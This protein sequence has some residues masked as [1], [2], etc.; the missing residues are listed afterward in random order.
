MTPPIKPIA[1]GTPRMSP[2]DLQEQVRLATQDMRTAPQPTQ[3]NPTDPP[4]PPPRVNTVPGF[5]QKMLRGFG[6]YASPTVLGGRVVD[7]ARS[8]G[9]GVVDAGNALATNAF[10]LG[11]S[12]DRTTGLGEALTPGFNAAFD[13]PGEGVH[14][15]AQDTG[16]VS[17]HTLDHFMG[18]RSDDPMAS[19]AESAAQFLTTYA[20]VPEKLGSPIIRAGIAQSLGFDP[21]EAGLAALAAQSPVPIARQLGQILKVDGDDSFL[22]AHLKTATEGIISIAL[23]DG[24]IASARFLGAKALL[25][26]G[27]LTPKGVALQTARQAEAAT[28]MTQVAD[29]SY[30][31]PGEA[32][33]VTP[34]PNG[35]WTLKA[36]PPGDKPVEVPLVDT[37]TP[38]VAPA[39]GA[40]PATP[41][42]DAPPVFRDYGE[43]SAQATTMNDRLTAQTEAAAPLDHPIT[44]R[45]ADAV[46]AEAKR[47]LGLTKPE[48]LA[49]LSAEVFNPSYANDLPHSQAV[50]DAV[51]KILK[52]EFDAAQRR[53]GGVPVEQSIAMLRSQ[54][55]AIPERELPAMMLGKLK[56]LQDQ[57]L[58]LLGGD[59][60]MR[61]MGAKV[62]DMSAILDARPHDLVAQD[63]A[64][65]AI[66]HLFDVMYWLAGANSETGRALAILKE[67][68]SARMAAAKI[69]PRLEAGPAPVK[70]A[71]P[72]LDP[73]TVNLD[74]TAK[75]PV[76]AGAIEKTADGPTLTGLAPEEAALKSQRKPSQIKTSAEDVAPAPYTAGMRPREVAAVARMVRSAG[77]LPRNIYAVAQAASIVTKGGRVDRA[78][79]FFAN[80]MLSGPKTHMSVLLSGVTTSL[81]EP[82]VK[83]GTGAVMANRAQML[84]GVDR[85]YGLF[86]YA[87][88]N[89]KSY[90]EALD[91]GRSIINPQPMHHEISG[92]TGD[93][94]RLP[95]RNLMALDE[96]T[97][98]SNYRAFVRARILRVNRASYF[99]LEGPALAMHVDDGL[100][101]AF[102]KNTGI[103]LF[104]EALKY[105]EVP[106]FSGAL[107]D[108]T[109][110]GRAH[111]YI[112]GG[113]ETRLVAMFVKASVNLFRYTWQMTP[114]L[115]VLNKQALETMKAGGEAAAELHARSL[116]GLSLFAFGA[117]QAG[118]DNLTGSGPSD[119]DM[120]AEWRKTH[121]PYSIRVGG[122]WMSYRRADPFATPLG[123]MADMN[124]ILHD[125]ENKSAD[126][127]HIGYAFLAA[128]AHNLTSKTY[129]SGISQ[130]MDAFAGGDPKAME[131]WF[132]KTTAGFMVPQIMSQLNPDDTYREIRGWVDEVMSRIPGFS[133]TL[134]PA[135]NWLGE[136]LMKP[137]GWVNRSFNLF[138]TA[139]APK[140]QIEDEL[141]TLGKGF[142]KYPEKIVDGQIDL[143][144]PRYKEQKTQPLP[145]V[146]MMELLRNPS[147]GG[148]SLRD[149]ITE[150]LKSPD[151]KDAN[152]G[153]TFL[154]GG[155][156]Y[157]MV[158]GIKSRHESQALEQVMNEY[159]K[160]QTAFNT[161]QQLR[162]ASNEGGQPAVDEIKRTANLFN[163]R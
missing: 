128:V 3:E 72:L 144:D 27:K 39:E 83:A 80:A 56:T 148:P 96:F 17:E 65:L 79:E 110:G 23:I 2:A 89:I 160:L 130:F 100:R 59:W 93:I 138:Q 48:E 145:Y 41:T 62:A 4:P 29:G 84:E 126:W 54:I 137:P 43:A 146:R 75:A 147:G 133:T 60:Y 102:D 91:A 69:A 92:V 86:L 71:G 38:P 149:D 105:A 19:F 155:R 37:Q 114:L 153:S 118:S 106:T 158:A 9:R 67:R 139:P 98:V 42:A 25:A 88:D 32:V 117:I 70:A 52:E 33:H 51:V 131:K 143:L 162:G 87:Q 55:G 108:D 124:T 154:P 95:G 135:H 113:S 141:L 30:E 121:E 40:A 63:N 44:P 151:W 74:K 68:G 99:P 125:V 78:M 35:E 123:I 10:E 64:R 13:T 16:L 129:M 15:M 161:A 20:L 61:R 26:G 49:T 21:H 111:K 104:P 7:V 142:P 73:H 58:W 119:P 134:P 57:H 24:L 12:I 8:A 101:A 77:G 6:P 132:T 34:A 112:S 140:N 45:Q 157:L 163:P 90:T 22:V 36:L 103:A 31:A 159:P 53:P 156:R 46:R 120:R 81:L 28:V 47:L 76:D 152:S 115:N 82:M 109:P 18:A 1:Q 14:G 116:V 127:E 85:L 66:N 107:G 11:A 94:V 50:Q 97:R 150:L 136:K 122:Q 5:W